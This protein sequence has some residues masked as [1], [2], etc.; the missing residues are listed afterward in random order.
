VVFERVLYGGRLIASFFREFF[1]KIGRSA[2]LPSKIRFRFSVSDKGNDHDS[3]EGLCRKYMKNRLR[4][5]K[6]ASGERKY[7]IVTDGKYATK[8]WRF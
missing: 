1:V 7:P 6:T 4:Q 5:K 2:K 8:R 3:E